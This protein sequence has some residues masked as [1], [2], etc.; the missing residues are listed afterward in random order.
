MKTSLRVGMLAIT[1]VLVISGC[2]ANRT[3]TQ[4]PIDAERIAAL[5]A[6]VSR[7]EAENANL[8]AA[9]ETLQA[10]PTPTPTPTPT[11][12]PTRTP[13]PTPTPTPSYSLEELLELLASVPIVVEEA[14]VIE[15]DPE[16]KSLFPD[17]IQV[18]VR[19]NGTDTIR[20]MIVCSL[21]YDA[22]G[23]PVKIET[24]FDFSGGS[25]ELEGRADDVNAVPGA[26]FGDDKGW[27]LDEHHDIAYVIAC[28]REAT[29]YNG[30]R[31]VNPYYQAWRDMFKEKPLPE[32]LRR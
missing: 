2:A 7:L 9:V 16:Y 1:V 4:A 13:Q 12:A 30:D 23:Y 25:Y 8:Q 15:Q 6:A 5:E 17:M 28:V 20:S 22:N 11:P 32:A 24:Q 31:W 21:A 27:S 10:E 14:R 29:Y 18:L 26:I 19:N 3:E